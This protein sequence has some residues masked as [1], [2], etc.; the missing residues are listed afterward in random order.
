MKIL[1][2]GPYPPPHGGVQT[3]VVAL[4]DFLRRRGIGCDVVNLTRFKRASENGIYYPP[5][6]LA[7]AEHLLSHRYDFI[8]LHIGG[9]IWARQLA[10]AL[11]CAALPH[12]KLVF[13]FH[14]GGY[15]SSPEGRSAHAGT[16]RAF[17]LRRFDALI[18]VNE[19]IAEFF[20]TLGVDSERIHVISPYL[21]FA[22]SAPGKS[23]LPAKVS[24]FMAAHTPVLL[25]VG[26]L[27][28]Q[29]DVS[30]QMKALGI[31][32]T[33]HPKAGLLV[34]GSGSLDEVVRKECSLLPYAEHI[35]LNGD[36]AHEATLQ[37]MQSSD[38]MLRTTW[39][40]GDAISVREALHF[41]VPV[42]ASDNGMR[43]E[44]TNLIPVRDL[45]A[46]VAM[47]EKILK[48][49]PARVPIL[50]ESN[51][52]LEKVLAIYEGLTK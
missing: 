14:S 27:E 36:L 10:L 52:N 6:A 11:T 3:H 48:S 2:L 45:Q 25:S 23:S 15:P 13:T 44:G 20:R 7:V 21:G 12:T 1:Q 35:L 31:I 40:D 50:S 46:L 41:G 37:A 19:E 49:P 5:N 32:R 28:P 26:G 29:Y 43:P 17:V 24:D 51:R 8:H 47:V 34:A 42:I 30:L 18:A 16:L 4:V 38:I 33:R 22:A 9:R 39:Y